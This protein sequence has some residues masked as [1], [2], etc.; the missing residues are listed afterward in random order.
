VARRSKNQLN[1]LVIH[2]Q[3][4]IV[5]H[6]DFLHHYL[7]HETR[8]ELLDFIAEIRPVRPDGTLIDGNPLDFSLQNMQVYLDLFMEYFN[9]SY[10]LIHVATLDIN[11]TDP[12]ALL[13]MIL[14]GATFKDKDSHQLSVC[15][16]DAI[17]PYILSGLLGSRVPDLSILQ[18]CLILECYGMYRAGPY[19]RENAI[20]IHG[21]LLNVRALG[22]RNPG[23]LI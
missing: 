20:L 4:I 1:M 7:S 12:V 14:S 15:L 9:S 23:N 18:A 13:S 22:I 6:R 19:Q 10:P 8:E 3:F 16:Y 11:L 2:K 21:L 5:A 17:I